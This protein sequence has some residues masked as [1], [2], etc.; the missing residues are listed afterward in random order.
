VYS[1]ALRQIVP[2]DV[3]LLTTQSH[4][5]FEWI[6]GADVWAYD[7]YWAGEPLL[8]GGGECCQGIE[9]II[10]GVRTIVSYIAAFISND[11]S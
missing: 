6:R 3:V 2:C 11:R 8:G 1:G 7:D 4:T 5:S 10:T 9:D